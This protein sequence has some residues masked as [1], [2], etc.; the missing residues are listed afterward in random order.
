MPVWPCDVWQTDDREVAER[1]GQSSPSF[2]ERDFERELRLQA[3]EG[4]HGE[5]QI[6]ACRTRETFGTLGEFDILEKVQMCVD[7]C[8]I[9]CRRSLQ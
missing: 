5:Q 4:S 1:S 7:S 6:I 2:V 9:D 8:H 3:D